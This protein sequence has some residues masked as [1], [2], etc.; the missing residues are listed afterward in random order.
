MRNFTLSFSK[1]CGY[2]YYGLHRQSGIKI[3][4][5][6]IQETTVGVRLHGVRL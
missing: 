4:A 6:L 1:K 3:V 2:A 5:S